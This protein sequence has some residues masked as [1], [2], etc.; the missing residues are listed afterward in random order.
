MNPYVFASILAAFFCCGLS[1]LVFLKARNSPERLSFAAV[2]FLIGIWTLFPYLTSQSSGEVD[3]L[4]LARW[5]YIAALYVPSLFFKFMLHTMR[6]SGDPKER[7]ILIGSY[8]VATLFLLVIPTPFFI[9]GISKRLPYPSVQ[10]GPLYFLF[11]LYFGFMYF[12]ASVRLWKLYRVASGHFREHLK[13]IGLAFVLAFLSGVLHFGSAFGVPEIIP[14]DFLVISYSAI[15]AFAIIK[16]R[17]MDIRVAIARTAILISVYALLLGTPLV[18]FMRHQ[19]KILI[20]MGANRWLAPLLG[21]IYAALASCGPFI[22]LAIQ[23]RAENRMLAEQR[24]YQ[25]VLR[26]AS[27]GMTLIKDLNK[28]LRLI[29]HLLTQKV[30]L[31]HAAIYLWDAQAKRFVPSVSRQW[32]VKEPEAFPREHPLIEYLHWHRMPIVTEELAL[33]ARGGVKELQPVVAALK[34]I[35]AAVAVPS[36]AEDRC[37]G[38]LLLGDKISGALFSSDDL[39]VFQVLASQA[40][41]AIENAKFYEE[42]KR[43]QTDLFQTAKMASLGHMAGGMSHQINNRFHV[44]SILSGTLRSVMRDLNPMVLEREKIKDLWDKTLE[45]LAKLE[46]NAL[47]GGE[48]VKTLLRFS[49]PAGDYKPVTLRQVIATAKEVAQFRVNMGLID[50]TEEIPE[51]LPPVK[52]DLNQLSDSCFNLLTNAYDAVQKKETMIREKQISPSPNDPTPFRGKIWIRAY[53]EETADKLLNV[54]EVQDNG[55]GM[56]HDELDNLFVP[57]FTT[58]AT[59]QKGTGL[60]LYV[61]QRI[62]ERH[63]GS[64]TA[65]S[66]LGAGTTFIIRLP[67]AVETPQGE[68]AHA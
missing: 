47:R 28:L 55:T 34:S 9:N 23:R 27:Q 65:A 36:F 44:L 51:S 45:T 10:P 61:I 33:Q 19:P 24:R 48:I 53:P 3:S 13:Y 49:R 22:Y 54:L 52:G 6:I 38:F 63:G 56:T 20:A 12:H 2:T 62:V 39:Q 60:G 46:D 18:L 58:K 14:H 43:T 66:K 50:L 29:V 57:F 4:T 37:E 5:V 59:A 11:I 67:A 1:L 32:P 35:K 31:R 68:P 41:L 40:A 17:I 42:L 64:I 16:Y 7:R 21:V 8:A 26:Q 30:R 15:I 25:S